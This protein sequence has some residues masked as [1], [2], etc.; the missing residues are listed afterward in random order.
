[1]LH[2]LLAFTGLTALLVGLPGA[3]IHFVG[4]PL[5]DHIPTVDEIQALLFSPMNARVLLDAL[6]CLCWIVW[7]FF[8]LDVLRCTVEAALGVTWPVV[9]RTGP[10]NGLVA[11]LVGTIVVTLL[12]NR[13]HGAPPAST[14]VASAHPAAVSAPLHPGAVRLVAAQHADPAGAPVAAAPSGMVQVTEEVRV[15]QNGIHDS[16][17]RVSERILHDGNRW[18]ELYR[19]N[20][21]IVQPDG[22]ALEVPHLIQPG[23]KITAYVS[24]STWPATELPHDKPRPVPT[25]EPPR[26]TTTPPDSS[27]PPSPNSKSASPETDTSFNAAGDEAAGA[28]LGYGVFVSF[29][30]AGTVVTALAANRMWHR[31][32]YRIGSGRRSDLHRPIAPVV[33]ALRLVHE[34]DGDQGSAT[35]WAEHTSTDVTA[36]GFAPHDGAEL[37]SIPIGVRDGRDV[38][39]NLMSTRGLGLVGP[40]AT[41]AV[42]ALLLHLLAHGGQPAASVR[43]LVPAADFDRIFSDTAVGGLPSAIVVVESLDTALDQMEAALL[44][45]TRQLVEDEVKPETGVLVLFAA[46]SPHAERRLQAVLDNG[47][48][49]GLAAIF[50]GQW[51][52]GATARV[53]PDGTVSATS[54]GLG[55][56]LA[57]TRLFT[58]PSTD[59][60]ELL[61]LLGEAECPS[62]D[63]GPAVDHAMPESGD[64]IQVDKPPPRAPEPLRD[65]AAQEEVRR[66]LT[67]RVL[68]PVELELHQDGGTRALSGTLTPKQREV[69]AFLALHPQGVRREALNEAVWPDSRPPRPFNS[70]HNALSLLRRALSRAT[71]RTIVDLILNEDGRY[72]LNPTLISTDYGRLHQVLPASRLTRDQTLGELRDAIDLYQ[73]DLAED[74]I[75]SW[76]EPFRESLRRD[77]LDALA[78]LIRAHGTD[79][80]EAALTLLEQ[81]RR[82]DPYNEGVYCDIIRNQARLGRF[83]AIPRTL[84]LLAATLDEIGERPGGDTVELAESLQGRSARS[85]TSSQ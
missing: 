16:L 54:A 18:P 49:V 6:A 30:L 52:S 5:P 42:R 24:V 45:R 61:S 84:K 51:R 59:G 60:A 25:D 65:R 22:R 8:A 35:S 36:S 39:L 50:L 56:V 74:V 58:L 85:A 19:L 17:W 38:A 15:P 68:G 41:A 37:S 9:H 44:T 20:L 10:L 57:D 40:G 1:M 66:P 11:A 29:I 32:R 13:A 14:S 2:G 26:P 76:V 47:S 28:D 77:V 83:A 78:V 73:G 75:A 81:T 80:P 23:W 34:R 63:H 48:T 53:R 46:P 70:L 43:I 3:L 27:R 12:T 21:G 62:E 67:L 33:R 31:R 64:V 55:D 69:L 72:R 7:F 4:W 71:D 79:E 82:L